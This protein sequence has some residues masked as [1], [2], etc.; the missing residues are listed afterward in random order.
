MIWVVQA[1]RGNIE[2]VRARI[3]AAAERAGR[4]PGDVTLVAVTKT[5][6]ARRVRMAWELGLT[7]FGE[8]RVQEAVEKIPLV[9]SKEKSEIRSPKPVLSPVEVSEVRW[10]LIGHLQRNKVRHAIPLFD[11]VHSVDSVRLAR[12]IDRRAGLAGKAMPVLIEVNVAGEA[13]KYGFAP[14]ALGEAVRQIADLP[15]VTIGGLMTVAP[16]TEDTEAARPFFRRLRRLRDGLAEQFPDI[17]WRHLS[18]G[19]TDDFEVAIEEGATL[20][21]IGRAIFGERGE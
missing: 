2:Q 21:R 4:D 13:S 5:V 20:V 1:L 10:H 7:D 18:M 16:I 8:N 6:P 15:S 12:E 11:M 17:D 3:A 9:I 19:M 14:Q